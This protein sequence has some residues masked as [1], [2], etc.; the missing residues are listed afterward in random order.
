MKTVSNILHF[1]LRVPPR[2]VAEV[3]CGSVGTSVS[4]GPGDSA[5]LGLRKTKCWLAAWLQQ[6]WRSLLVPLLCSQPLGHSAIKATLLLVVI[7]VACGWSHKRH[8]QCILGV[9]WQSGQHSVKKAPMFLLIFKY[10]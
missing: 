3:R 1:P 8:G 9:S 7:A 10:I 4:P 5:R 6:R 2:N